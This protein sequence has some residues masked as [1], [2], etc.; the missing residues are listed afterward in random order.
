VPGPTLLPP[1]P[2]PTAAE[3]KNKAAELQQKAAE[4]GNLVEMPRPRC[5]RIRYEFESGEIRYAEGRHAQVLFDFLEESA[6][7][8]TQHGLATYAGPPFESYD[9]EDAFLARV[10]GTVPPNPNT[11]V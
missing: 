3:L 6:R 9:S 5:T 4:A 7:V 2:K 8:A 1:K 11:F 10:P